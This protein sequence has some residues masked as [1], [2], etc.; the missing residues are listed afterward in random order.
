MS[1]T[2]RFRGAGA[3][4]QRHA[5]ENFIILITDTYE[6]RCAAT[7]EKALPVLET[8][9]IRPVAEGGQH[10]IDNGLLLRSDLHRLYD[11]GYI[12]VTRDLVLRASRRLR[13]E[14]GN[15]EIYFPLDGQR[16]WVPRRED[17]P[18]N[19]EALAWHEGNVYRP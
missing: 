2:L 9:H 19:R 13:E 8:A 14:F 16:I 6:R 15:G 18:P 10:R 3:R 1:D 7:G 12:T 5:P 11:R 4:L 17:V